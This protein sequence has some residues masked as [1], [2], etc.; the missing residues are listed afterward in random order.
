M[1]D[2]YV[3]SENTHYV[4]HEHL[5]C[6]R[7]PFFGRIFAQSP[8]AHQNRSFGLPDDDDAAFSLFVRWLY[9]GGLPAGS[10]A[11]EPRAEQDL[12][13]LLELYLMSER[14]QVPELARD[15]LAVIRRFYATADTYPGLRRVQYICANT[16]RDSPLRHLFLAAVARMLVLRSEEI[17][18]HWERALQHSGELALEVIRAVQR[19]QLDPEAVPD[20]RFEES[21]EKSV[22]DVHAKDEPIVKTEEGE[23]KVSDVLGNANDGGNKNDAA[24]NDADSE[25]MDVD[26]HKTGQDHTS[27]DYSDGSLTDES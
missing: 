8:S 1:V 6:H 15:V 16:V 3:G 13:P 27:N 25:Q 14:W 18:A 19:W 21:V 10:R 7:A 4:L 11:A 2:I 9:A 26:S 5:L 23:G 22:R 17:P 20:V 24:G 12:A